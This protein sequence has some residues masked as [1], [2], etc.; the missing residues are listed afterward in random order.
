MSFVN[1]FSRIFTI[2]DG[3][4]PV[5]CEV[6]LPMVCLVATGVSWK[7]NVFL[8]SALMF[9]FIAICRPLRVADG[10]ETTHGI[11]CKCIHRCIYRKC[12]FLETHYGS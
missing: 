9:F 1:L 3:I 7:S 6:P 8:N 2:Q 5:R 4:S 10:R 11:H 12:E